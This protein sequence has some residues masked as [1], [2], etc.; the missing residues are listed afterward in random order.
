MINS[1]ALEIKDLDFDL[2]KESFKTF[3]KNQNEFK[4]Y[5]FDGS[6]INSLLDILSYNT[7]YN[8]FY[9]NMLVNESF[10]DS[11]T[12]RASLVSLS[13]PVGF[14]P[15]SYQSS[16]FVCQIIID[17]T[18][19]DTDTLLTIPKYSKF[20]TGN[21][22]FY[23][24]ETIFLQRNDNNQ[25]ISDMIVLFEG[26]LI[27]YR[28]IVQDPD[29]LFSIPYKRIDIETLA[30]Q[31]YPN[32]AKYELNKN[33]DDPERIF[34]RSDT[35]VDINGDS[36]IYFIQEDINGNYALSF[37]DDT[38]GKKL[39][40]DNIIELKFL[41]S[42][43]SAAN[44]LKTF[45]FVETAQGN[46][47][48]GN[49]SGNSLQIIPLSEDLE[50]FNGSE[51]Q[52]QESIRK[53]SPYHFEAQ[54]RI[55]T[56]NDYEYFI[57]Q[58]QSNIDILRLWGGEQNDPPRYGSVFCLIK[59]IDEEK[60]NA[61][62]K[63][64]LIDYIK[65]NSIV[66]IDF[67]IKDPNVIYI[68]PSLEIKINYNL[69]R[70][71]NLF[72]QKITKYLEEFINNF[73]GDV[74]RSSNLIYFLQN[75]DT[76]IRSV[77]IDLSLN[78]NIYFVINAPKTQIIEFN[79]PIKPGSF[80]SS[81]NFSIENTTVKNYIEEYFYD[82]SE[83]AI[84]YYYKNNLTDVVMTKTFGTINY[85]TGKVILNNIIITGY[86]DTNEYITFRAIPQELDLYS[87]QNSIFALNIDQIK[88][89]LINDSYK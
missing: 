84:I 72:N 61:F 57:R 59:P 26:E 12:Q 63:S 28:F 82:N 60:L 13:K 34:T 69:V 78:K 77:N 37:G 14:V 51:N 62:Q 76:Y 83:G 49:F 48:V 64:L 79:A 11:A 50:S 39:Y 27:T 58:Y 56:L 6:N 67:V 66:G 42:S 33:E 16:K 87:D 54:S 86:L 1:N 41:S 38:L 75:K 65:S 18:N 73:P 8:A 3:L 70:D 46:S 15:K 40:N 45:K 20:S 22:S 55:V 31:V 85:S 7:Y 24:L 68:V 89:T 47:Y 81:K 10:L 43:G 21:F 9:M 30:V 25:F 35:I 52:D 5:N 2:I 53:F 17:T 88:R 29:I 32:L 80:E 36:R 71:K 19:L 74:F 23:N 4:D 44:K